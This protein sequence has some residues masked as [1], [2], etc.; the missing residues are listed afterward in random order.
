MRWTINQ[1]VDLTEPNKIDTRIAARLFVGDDRAHSWKVNVM[2]SGT[3]A[4]L[5]GATIEAY[6]NRPDGVTVNVGGVAS[7]NAVEA[8]LPREAYEVPGVA[9]A[10]MKIVGESGEVI[11]VASA[12][13]LVEQGPYSQFIDPQ[14]NLEVLAI[15]MNLMYAEFDARIRDLESKNEAVTLT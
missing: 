7:G 10:N 13:M 3:P 12:R 11:T 4:D 9:Y 5:Q 14:K 8:V 15:A 1:R 2:D 6:V